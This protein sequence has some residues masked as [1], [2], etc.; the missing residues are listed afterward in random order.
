M[1]NGKGLAPN[2]NRHSTTYTYMSSG[3]CFG[4]PLRIIVLKTSL[5]MSI[6]KW[7]FRY[8]GSKQ[9]QGIARYDRLFGLGRQSYIRWYHLWDQCLEGHY[10]SMSTFV[11]PLTHEA[12]R[13]VFTTSR[14]SCA[15][16]SFW[17]Y[18]LFQIFAQR[19]CAHNALG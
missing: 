5:Q 14:L 7:T 13:R 3:M 1:D 18:A 17:P 8:A 9:P 15:I 2:Y 16:L 19:R 4:V 6:S 10:V 12:L 11:V